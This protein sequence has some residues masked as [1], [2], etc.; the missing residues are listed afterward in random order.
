MGGDSGLLCKGHQ[1][2]YQGRLHSRISHV[3][4]ARCSIA[5]LHSFQLETPR[6]EFYAFHPLVRAISRHL[7]KEREGEVVIGE[8]EDE[9]ENEGGRDDV[10]IGEVREQ[11][12]VE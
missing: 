8:Y 5:N 10:D 9:S 11:G 12:R 2:F 3:L 7:R 4:L 1:H 6:K